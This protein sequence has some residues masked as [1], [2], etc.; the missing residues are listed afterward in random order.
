MGVVGQEGWETLSCQTGYYTSVVHSLLYNTG[1][2]VLGI[3]SGPIL[4]PI[5]PNTFVRQY[6]TDTIGYV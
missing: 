5:I 4:F 3:A 6:K 1:L 2:P